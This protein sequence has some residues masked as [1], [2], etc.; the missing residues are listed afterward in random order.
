MRL[1]K[2]LISGVIVAVLALAW[3]SAAAAQDIVNQAMTSFPS[4][5]VRVEYSSPAKLRALPNFSS[6]RQ[7]YVGPS[8]KRLEDD[9]AQLG[10]Q[11][12]DVDELVI[13][14]QGSGLKLSGLAS[15]RFN[16]KS[17]AD[18]ATT[19]GL[20]AS[21]VGTATAYCFGA[22]AG[23][24]CVAILTDGLGAFGSLD[25]LGTIMKVRAGETPNAASD[26]AFAKHVEDARSDAAIWGVAVGPAIADWFKGWMPNQGN[27]QLDWTQTF[28][29]VEVLRYS[30]QTTDKV[31]LSVKMDCT[32]SQAAGS[33]TQVLQGL[34]LVQQMAWQNQNPTLHNP[35]QSLA[36]ERSDRQV[37]MN[38]TTAFN[39]LEGGL[40]G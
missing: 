37:R 4:G 36:V 10:I 20:A 28:Q 19:Q 3:P 22:E 30:V 6:L 2:A 40:Q 21:Q 17:I 25:S 35:F 5:T 11:E 32:S 18:H 7:R 26:A 8:I 15:G 33:L 29:A 31:Y 27:I 24:N 1:S 9:L 34:K 12:G 16:A 39:E 14:W 38:L 23:G 13:G